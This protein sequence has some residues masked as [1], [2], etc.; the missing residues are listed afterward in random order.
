MIK[1][2]SRV[3]SW[4]FRE[5]FSSRK[6]VLPTSLFSDDGN[7]SIDSRASPFVVYQFSLHVTN[8]E[9]ATCRDA[10]CEVCMQP[11]CNLLRRVSQS[12]CGF[13]KQKW[14]SWREHA[15]MDKLFCSGELS[16][17]RG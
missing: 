12:N 10:A 16:H 4:N 6:R 13:I 14:T 8:P 5:K 1:R 9:S 2:C 7:G 15:K 17:T 3:F 11:A